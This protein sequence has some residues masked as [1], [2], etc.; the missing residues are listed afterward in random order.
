M[1][2][3]VPHS[4]RYYYL[5]VQCQR[6][7]TQGLLAICCGAIKI[8]DHIEG[9]QSWK[10]C[11]IMASC[12]TPLPKSARINRQTSSLQ[13]LIP[14]TPESYPRSAP[15]N[16]YHLPSPSRVA[17]PQT[18]PLKRSS[19]SDENSIPRFI[20]HSS[21]AKKARTDATSISETNSGKLAYILCAI[22]QVNW[23]LSE[24]L[25]KSITI[26]TPNSHTQSLK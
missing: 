22:E 19:P 6:T 5:Q 26:H 21:S 3:I 12:T 14:S 2:F 16:P 9:R 4:N 11:F 8:P 20:L 15:A 10:V 25:Y 1:S 23:T 7:A 24:F 13:F 18:Y 17:A